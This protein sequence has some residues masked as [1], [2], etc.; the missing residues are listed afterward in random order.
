[1]GLIEALER[2]AVRL[3]ETVKELKGLNKEFSEELGRLAEEGVELFTLGFNEMLVKGNSDWQSSA[4]N[5]AEIEELFATIGEEN[6]DLENELEEVR[7]EVLSLLDQL[8]DARHGC[9]DL[10][11]ELRSWLEV[12]SEE[13]ESTAEEVTLFERPLAGIKDY[14]QAIEQVRKTLLESMVAMEGDP[15]AQVGREHLP[16]WFAS[17][18]FSNR[19]S[20]DALDRIRALAEDPESV[21]EI[22]SQEIDH[23]RKF[24]SPTK[25]AVTVLSAAC[26]K[27]SV[28]VSCLEALQEKGLQG[29]KPEG[30]MKRLKAFADPLVGL[31]HVEFLAEDH[32]HVNDAFMIR[33]GA[34]AGVLELAGDES[35]RTL[36]AM[37]EEPD[38][39][40]AEL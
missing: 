18:R 9:L 14:R 27:L 36:K 31:T 35:V 33:L 40:E 26:V 17:V 19:A 12:I 7:D 10:L 32:S 20:R 34:V 13:D 21:A 3:P 1:M 25:K 30:V 2:F 29:Q 4:E 11:E 23:L 37:L 22:L 16:D 24:I 39:V 28:C 5:R 6:S 8:E 38:S 15:G